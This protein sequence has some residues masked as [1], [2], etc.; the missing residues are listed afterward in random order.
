MSLN[1][2]PR[3]G[4]NR[5]FVPLPCSLG[6]SAELCQRVLLYSISP[7]PEQNMNDWQILPTLANPVRS[8]SN[9]EAAVLHSSCTPLPPASVILHDRRCLKMV[10]RAVCLPC[11]LVPLC[12]PGESCA[13][14]Q[15]LTPSCFLPWGKALNYITPDLH[16]SAAA[17]MPSTT[18]WACRQVPS[19]SRDKQCYQPLQGSTHSCTYT[20]HTAVRILVLHF[21]RQTIK[22]RFI[23]TDDINKLERAGDCGH[24]EW[25]QKASGIIQL[26]LGSWTHL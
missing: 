18:W 13:G 9:R 5:H 20:F 3:E 1:Q 7:R 25:R 8:E 26:L 21:P 14:H 11:D 17:Q 4:H 12:I 19:P 15:W 23:F 10:I 2:T 24:F 22:E 6:P 16:L